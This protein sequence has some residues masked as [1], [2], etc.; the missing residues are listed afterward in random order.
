MPGLG[1]LTIDLAANISRFEKSLSRAERLAEKRTKGIQRTITRLATGVGAALASFQFVRYTE[2]ALGFANT[3]ADTADKLG[4]TTNALQEY[5]FAAEQVGVAQ[6]ALD[7]GI[8]RFSRRVGEA[9]EGSGVL[10]QVLKDQNISLKDNNGRFKSTEV[11]LKEYA[12]AIANAENKNQQLLLAFK[13]FD[14]E[15]AALVNLFRQGSSGITSFADEAN[16]LGLVI[17]ESLIRNAAEA[18][19]QLETVSKVMDIQMT[20]AAIQLAPHLTKIAET[21][22]AIS[23]DDIARIPE[24]MKGIAV[25][26]RQTAEAAEQAAIFTSALLDVLALDVADVGKIP[27]IW[28]QYRKDV[29]SA[30]AETITFIDE[31]EGRGGI[32]LNPVDDIDSDTIERRMS[33]LSKRIKQLQTDLADN[34]GTGV[35]VL[36]PEQFDADATAMETRAKSFNESITSSLNLAGQISGTDS[37]DGNQRTF[38][39]TE[40]A[41]AELD[42]MLELFNQYETEIQ[43][44]R[45]TNDVSQGERLN[46]LTGITDSE[47][48]S[49]LGRAIEME[50]Y[51]AEWADTQGTK[52]IETEKSIAS[53]TQKFREIAYT[54]GIRLLQRFAADNKAAA[55]ILIGIQTA[56]AVKDIQIQAKVASA[57]VYALGQVEAAAH[58]AYFNYGAAAAAEARAAAAIGAIESA[59]G[60]A[61]A[62]TLATGAFDLADATRSDS[63]IST[64]GATPFRPVFTDDADQT[65]QAESQGSVSR[66]TITINVNGVVTD[67]IVQD[68]IVPAIQDATND[69]DVILFRNDSRQALEITS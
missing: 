26:F 14:T 57:N 60:V 33:G 42:R 39:D 10:N 56:K 62:F 48:E 13:A 20:E 65:F 52:R 21:F 50:T 8:Q 34:G 28:A 64:P 19:R 44:R 67:E 18:N 6:T 5:R 61:T 55:L 40:R 37:I 59:A 46:W 4:I 3:I 53:Q 30:R 49:D 7:V 27:D 11:I 17:D 25:G 43:R 24:S 38:F 54:S 23:S 68:L 35:G 47:M 12:D 45:Q 51:L 1:S 63:A 58:R 16:N 22:L 29:Q 9:Q 31:I 36:M 66:G 41:Q 2:Q 15:G 69:K 32:R